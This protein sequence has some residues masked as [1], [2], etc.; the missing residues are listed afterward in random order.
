[1]EFKDKGKMRKK[2]LGCISHLC[3]LHLPEDRKDCSTALGPNVCIPNILLS[4]SASTWRFLGSQGIFLYLP[5]SSLSALWLLCLL[6]FLSALSIIWFFDMS[7]IGDIVLGS[8]D[9]WIHT[10]LTFLSPFW[11]WAFLKSWRKTQCIGDFPMT[12]Q[13]GMD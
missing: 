4:S 7:W 6:V 11:H 13:I 5:P 2:D 10:A 9:H 8:S 3:C 12:Y 1:M